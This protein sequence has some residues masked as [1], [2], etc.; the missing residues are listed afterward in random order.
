MRGKTCVVTGASSG[1]GKITARELARKGAEVVAVCRDRGRGEAALASIRAAVRD[2]D[3]SLALCDFASQRSIR[4]LATE[5]EKLT[6]IH[7][8]VNNAGAIQGER[9]LTEDGLETTF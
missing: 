2:A 8:L 4:R 9:R 6:A 1:I 5:L 3:V 7:V